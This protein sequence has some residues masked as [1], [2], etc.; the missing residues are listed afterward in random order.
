M[1]IASCLAVTSLRPDGVHSASTS[2]RSKE[3]ERY[4]ACG[5]L[6]VYL[7]RCYTYT[8]ATHAFLRL[9]CGALKL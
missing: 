1:H 8:S 5:Q 4:I 3:N 7:A 2:E 6:Y 9:I